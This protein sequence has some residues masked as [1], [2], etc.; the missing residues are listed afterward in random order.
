MSRAVTF[1]CEWVRQQKASLVRL[2]RHC[3]PDRFAWS[4]MQWWPDYDDDLSQTEIAML[5]EIESHFRQQTLT[6]PP[7]RRRQLVRACWKLVLES[8][9]YVQG[10]SQEKK[11]EW[12]R[13]IFY[14]FGLYREP[15]L[16][17]A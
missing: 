9:F 16:K 6:M 7:N 8:D 3:T 10:T 17:V 5:K 2:A 12:T 15:M 1:T 11:E 14:R 13:S 4:L